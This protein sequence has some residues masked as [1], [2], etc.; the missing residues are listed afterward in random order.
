[1]LTAFVFILFNDKIAT[2]PP[3]RNPCENKPETLISDATGC[4]GIFSA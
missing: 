1:L 3:A 2:L 4:A